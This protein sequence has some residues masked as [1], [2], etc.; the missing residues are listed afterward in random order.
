MHLLVGK[1]AVEGLGDGPL[2]AGVR[3]A[4]RAFLYLSTAPRV[5][6]RVAGH[7]SMLTPP[8]S[9]GCH[10]FPKTSSS[11]HFSFAVTHPIDHDS[12]LALLTVSSPAYLPCCDARKR[13]TLFTVSGAGSWDASAEGWVEAQV[14][15]AEKAAQSAVTVGW[16]EGPRVNFRIA[17]AGTVMNIN[18]HYSTAPAVPRGFRR[19]PRGDIDL[20]REIH[21]DGR[22][23][24]ATLR[25]LYSAK[26]LVNG[27]RVDATVAVYQG[28]GA[29][30]EWRRDIKKYMA[31]WHPNIVQLYGT[32]SFGNIHATVFHDVRQFLDLYRHSHFST[33]YIYAYIAQE[34]EAFEDYFWGHLWTH[35]DLVPDKSAIYYLSSES[36]T[37]QGLQVL[38]AEN[39]EATVID[40]LTLELYHEISYWHFS[41]SRFTSFSPSVTAILGSVF[42]WP[43]DDIFDD[44]VEI[45]WLPNVEGSSDLSW[46]DSEYGSCLGEL[47]PDGWTRLKSNDTVGMIAW[48]NFDILDT[49]FWPSQANHILTTLQISSDFEDYVVV[50]EIHFELSVS[51]TEEDVPPGFLFL[52]PPAHFQTGKCAFKWP[53]CP[54]Y[55]SLDP[56]G[57]DRLTPEDAANLGFPSFQLSTRLHGWS[58]DASVY[59]GIR[60]FHQAKGFDPDSQDVARHL[61]HPLYQVPGPSPFAHIDEEYYDGNETGQYSTDAEP[62]N[63]K[64][65]LVPALTHQDMEEVPVSSRF[66]DIAIGSTSASSS[67]S[68]IPIDWEASAA[69]TAYGHGYDIQPNPYSS[70]SDFSTSDLNFNSNFDAYNF[71]NDLLWLDYPV[72]NHAAPSPSSLNYQPPMLYDAAQFFPATPF[73]QLPT[74]LPAASSF[75]IDSSSFVFNDAVP[76]TSNLNYQ[77]PILHDGA[78]FVPETLWPQLPTSLPVSSSFPSAPVVYAL[79]ADDPSKKRKTRDETD[80]ANIGQGSRGQK[81][82]K[83]F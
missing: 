59:A 73:P 9:V 51:T 26:I 42:H 36:S 72:F 14:A 45:A 46:C 78:Q 64:H 82:P 81:A 23:G 68:L 65:D 48:I 24:V 41:K 57:A 28:D 49:E 7:S 35:F 33:V 12:Q 3:S 5:V 32:A 62:D 63:P 1:T 61:G 77:P 71:G 13:Y 55:L 17:A 18:K 75:P 34:F 47:I 39:M 74:R 15:A 38:S 40:S 19:I 83:R 37:Q 10:A 4:S 44:A 58:W 69:G 67:T 79:V 52:C 16:G 80:L 8:R 11:R 54:A 76:F 60:H 2:T 30:Q 70:T 20:Q 31:V 25:K 56:S 6:L 66:G 27:E 43:S 21:F 29:E 22:S 53:D 50:D